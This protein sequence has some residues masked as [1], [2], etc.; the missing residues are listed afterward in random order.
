[1]T[2]AAK[3]LAVSRSTPLLLLNGRLGISPET[4]IRLSEAFGGSPE[5]WLTQQIQ[6]DLRHALQRRRPVENRKSATA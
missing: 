4:A 2:E 5:S 6:Y 1:M 3:E